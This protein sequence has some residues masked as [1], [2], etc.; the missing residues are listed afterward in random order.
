MYVRTQVCSLVQLT[1]LALCLK[2]AAKITHKAQQIVAIVSKWHA[3][4]TC[5]PSALNDRSSQGSGLTYGP[6]HP[7]LNRGSSSE[8]LEGSAREWNSLEEE[9]AHDLEAYQKRQAL[10]NVSFLFRIVSCLD[11]EYKIDRCVGLVEFGTV[12]VA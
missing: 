1:G 8:D 6:A 4:A 12:I 11:F 3:L 5:S 9:L 7:N 2:G 10:G